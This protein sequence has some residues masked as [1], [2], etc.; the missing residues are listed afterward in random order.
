MTSRPVTAVDLGKSRCR[1]TVRDGVRQMDL[2]AE[3]TPGLAAAGG[4]SAAFDAIRGLL[5]QADQPVSDLVVGAAG[6]WAAPDGA[7]ELAGR[8]AELTNGRVAVTSDVITAHVGA[9]AGSAGVLLIAGTGAA[10]LGVDADGLRLID[11]WGPDVGDFGSGSWLGREALRAVLRASSGLGPHTDLTAAL[12]ERVGRASD[13]P[14]WLGRDGAVPRRLATL[15]PAVLDAAAGGDRVAAEIATEAL[16]LLVST[17]VAATSRPLPVALHGGLTDHG[18]F[19]SAL[20]DALT[21]VGR[22][23]MPS[24]GDALAGALLLARRSDLPHERLVHRAE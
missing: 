21:A 7:A 18:W 1:L 14:A 19:R 16:R 3:G 12:R 8:L 22:T 23:V 9:L 6:A 2:E 17:A 5:A 15:A 24:A 20:Q 4:V 11:G 13:I 10:A